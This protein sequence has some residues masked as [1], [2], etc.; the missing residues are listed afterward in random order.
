MQ[1]TAVS[2]DRYHNDCDFKMFAVL[3]YKSVL[4]IQI[5]IVETGCSCYV[6][7]QEY[8]IHYFGVNS[9]YHCFTVKDR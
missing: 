9:R 4:K 6:A 1:I 7:K 8:S 3:K 2:C 5:S